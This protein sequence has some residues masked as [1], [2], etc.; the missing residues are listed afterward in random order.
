V[1]VRLDA[2]AVK[3]GEDK[4]EKQDGV[5]KSHAQYPF[6]KNEKNETSSF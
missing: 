4:Y 5:Q 3:G 2:I 6:K 1:D